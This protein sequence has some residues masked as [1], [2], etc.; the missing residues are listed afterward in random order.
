MTTVALDRVA[1]LVRVPVRLGGD[2]LRFLVDTGI[3]VSVVGTRV[4]ARPDVLDL[5]RTFAGRRMS[6]QVVE[7]PLVRLPELA[8][9]DHV[10][11][12]GLV[13]AD[14]LYPYR[15]SFDLAGERMVLGPLS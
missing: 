7:A 5:G 8:V 15:F 12:D 6:G 2:D 4:A 11:H 9:G 13:G 14:I 1:H 10:V 3:G